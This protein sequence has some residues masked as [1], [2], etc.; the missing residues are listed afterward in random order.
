MDVL[1]N[2]FMVNENNILLNM[3]VLKD[4]FLINE[5]NMLL[6]ERVERLYPN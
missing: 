1:K 4:Y 3:S 2:Y 6:N 5:N